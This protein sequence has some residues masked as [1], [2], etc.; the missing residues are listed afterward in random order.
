MEKTRLVAPRISISETF[1]SIQGEGPYTGVPSVFLRTASC[2][3]TCP[4]FPCDTIDVWKKVERICKPEDLIDLF[5]RKDWLT[6]LRNGSHLVITGGEPLLQ[7]DKLTYFLRLLRNLQ[8]T[9]IEVETNGTILPH[10]NFDLYVS[11]YNVSPK[12]SSSGEPKDK[13]YKYNVL[14]H[15]TLSS[16]SIFKFVLTKPE[17]INEVLNDFVSPLNIPSSR[18]Y[19]MPCGDTHEQLERN[20]PWVID[21]CK[22]Y[23]FRFCPRVHIHIY[24]KTVGV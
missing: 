23:S 5:E 3:L 11:W 19:L 15:F 6:Y 7:Q 17:D 20:S 1:Y 18:V 10:K 14:Q 21:L 24:N 4:G 8:Y 12:L 9:Y 16:K 22:K 2:N 13:R